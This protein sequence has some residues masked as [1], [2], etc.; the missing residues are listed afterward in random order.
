M[1]SAIATVITLLLVS[2]CGDGT[3]SEAPDAGLEL[4]IDPERVTV[5]GVS[6]GAYMAGQFHVAHSELISGAGLLAGGPWY[7]A[8]GSMS[9]AL[10]PCIKGGDIDLEVSISQVEQL[11]AS[12]LID[13]SSNLRDDRVWIFHGA[14]D[15]TVHPS[16]SAAAREFYRRFMSPDQI[17]FIDDIEVVHGMPTVSTGHAC[18]TFAA[19]FLN[20]CNYDAAGELLKH[21]YGPLAPP[22]E[23]SAEL[24]TLTQ[25]PY[26]D[27]ELADEAWLYVPDDC[28]NGTAC[29][30]H[31]AFHGCAQSAEAVGDAFAKGA[32]FN[33]WAESNR[34][35]VLYPQVKSS[36]LAPVNPL[37]CWDWWGYTGDGYAT[38]SGPQID[39]VRAMIDSLIGETP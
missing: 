17:A 18:D 11:A 2:A 19:P 16:A 23:A 29:G 15:D 4:R 9:Q 20:A 13:D 25:K 30:L 26:D 10:G 33:E 14:A 5:S 36:K 39:A 35:V 32:G 8:G 21:L 37:G 34:L 28:R 7:C 1:R 22:T 6:S 12:G 24:L 31:I 27:A 38:K 3:D